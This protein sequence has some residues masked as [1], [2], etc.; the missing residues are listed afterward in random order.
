M[1]PP[2]FTSDDTSYS[3]SLQ[4]PYLSLGFPFQIPKKEPETRTASFR[5][6][7]LSGTQFSNR[8]TSQTLTVML[9]PNQSRNT[10][11]KKSIGDN[12]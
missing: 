6:T 11:S 4:I 8:N 3:A 1:N 2:G 12:C 9:N 5:L 10:P 7:D